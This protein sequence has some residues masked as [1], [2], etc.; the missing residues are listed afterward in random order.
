MT[1][2]PDRSR[3]VAM[4]VTIYMN[5][6]PFAMCMAERI[7]LSGMVIQL[8]PWALYPESISEVAFTRETERGTERHRAAVVLD[9]VRDNRARLL[10]HSM[11]SQALEA[12]I[13]LLADDGRTDEDEPDNPASLPRI[14]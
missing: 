14:N 10:F 12:L 4:L 3:D 8:S 1:S 2:R 6:M 11:D 9:E 7:S 5:G 13:N